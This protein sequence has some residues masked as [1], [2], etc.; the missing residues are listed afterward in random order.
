MDL[1]IAALLAQDG[2]TNGAIYALMSLALVLVFAVTRIVFVP[3]GEFLAYGALTLASLEAGRVPG[4]VWLLP[5]LGALAFA[6]DL[7]GLVRRPAAGPLLRAAT[8][9]LL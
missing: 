1:Q 5:V 3:Q 2:I 6:F 7:P 9:H 4:T 8:W